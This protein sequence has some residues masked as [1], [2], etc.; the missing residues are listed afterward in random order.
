[1]SSEAINFFENHSMK[2]SYSVNSHDF[3]GGLEF[4]K[5]SIARLVFESYSSELANALQEVKDN[6]A[7]IICKNVETGIYI[8]LH[9]VEISDFVVFSEFVTLGNGDD[10]FEEVE[11]MF[12][13]LSVWFDRMHSFKEEGE[14]I[15]RDTNTEKFNEKFT[16]NGRKYNIQN[17]QNL[18]FEKEGLLK[19]T[20][21]NEHTILL[22]K[23]EGVF[24][25]HEVRDLIH[26][27]RNLFS[28]LLGVPLSVLYVY[29]INKDNSKGFKR[30]YFP[31]ALNSPEPLEHKHHAFSNFSEIN[32]HGFF[33]RI[34]SNYFSRESFRN[35]WNRLPGTYE[36]KGFWEF[37]ILSRIV[38][39]ELYAGK[40]SEKY[41]TKMEVQN[42]KDLKNR[43]K[44]VVDLFETEVTLTQDDKTAYDSIKKRVLDVGNT[45]IQTLQE[46]FLCLMSTMSEDLRRVI[47]FSDADFKL[48]KQLRNDTAH[49]NE[50]VKFSGTNIITHEMQVSDR[51]LVLLISFSYLDLGFS[52]REIAKFMSRSFCLFLRNAHINKRE[53]DLFLDTATFIELTDTVD[54]VLLKK[55]FLAIK[56]S[57]FDGS[58]LL[59]DVLSKMMNSDFVGSGFSDVKDYV[60]SIVDY[61]CEL[62][63]ISKLYLSNAGDETIHYGVLIV[64]V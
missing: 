24:E 35:I 45:S 13:G 7:D 46:I 58:Y 59:E 28:L 39:L 63:W 9:E 1:M 18:K 40:I 53:L 23:D 8:K 19:T 56:H 34:F 36:Y 3:Q 21:T 11:V 14:R 48:I 54:S 16:F 60:N 2:V 22:K 4:G 12:T 17:N 32:S 5:G 55:C 6:S 29:T 25:Y 52:E 37:S 27:V 50:Y 26:E 33:G 47:N 62:E 43:I 51:L 42:F 15:F 20:I 57:S 31:S 61:E 44:K 64:R 38:V 49:G 41:K 30:L 10:N